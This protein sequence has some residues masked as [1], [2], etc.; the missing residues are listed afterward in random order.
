MRLPFRKKKPA[1]G[2]LGEMSLLDHLVE[3]RKRLIKSV[4]SVVVAAIVVWIVRIPLLEFI[5]APYCSFQLAN[6]DE[7]TC[8]FLQSAPMEGFSVSLT[9]A[10]YGGILLATPIILYQ[11]GR[12]VLP[13]LYPNEKRML[14][15]FIGVSVVLLV[16][17][18]VSAFALL[19]KALDVLFGFGPESYEPLFAPRE[20]IG[21]F[22][23][24]LFAFGLAAQFPLVLIF[25]QL[26]GIVQTS[27]LAGNRRIAFVGVLILGAIIT[28]TGDPFMLAVISIPMY[29]S[30]E[31]AILVGRQM[32]KRREV[33][34]AAGGFAT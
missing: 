14:F 9:V 25:L 31:L 33:K 21:F 17:G 22:V 6:S 5:E 13:G 26:V 20:Y 28:P 29:I 2:H 4:I 8:R 19:P 1:Q 30:Y 10:G 23:K 11:I 34:S 15:P 16:A 27:T 7:E 32:T 12:F 24:M 18:M 3:L